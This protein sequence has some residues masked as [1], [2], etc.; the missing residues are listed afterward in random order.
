V[1]HDSYIIDRTLLGHAA[2][3]GREDVVRLLLEMGADPNG[4]GRPGEYT[5][6]MS[7]VFRGDEEIAAILIEHGADPDL[8]GGLIGRSPRQMAEEKGNQRML[9]I[10]AEAGNEDGGDGSDSTPANER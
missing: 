5:P 10:L 1:V 9:S 7:A 8:G 2:K 4:R 3:K 6:L